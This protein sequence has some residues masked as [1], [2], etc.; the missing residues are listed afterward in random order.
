MATY[1]GGGVI[2]SAIYETTTALPVTGYALTSGTASSQVILGTT[3]LVKPLGVSAATAN[4]SGT[5]H[6]AFYLPGQTV[7]AVAG[8]AIS[9][10]DMVTATTGG[11][12]IAATKGGV[13]T[14]TNFVWGIAI[15]AAG[16]DLDVFELMFQP[17][18]MEI[19]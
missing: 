19:T 6:I 1:S 3:A 18:E 13:Q 5:G 15:T 12:F 7:K 16:A 11:K 10:G 4:N 2:A 8:G 14:E 17:F 9:K